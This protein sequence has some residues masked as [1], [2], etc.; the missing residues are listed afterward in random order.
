MLIGLF[1]NPHVKQEMKVYVALQCVTPGDVPD[2]DGMELL[3]AGD[4]L[5]FCTLKSLH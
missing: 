2:N 3:S 5:H 4:R 1:V